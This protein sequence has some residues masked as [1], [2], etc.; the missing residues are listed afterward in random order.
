MKLISQIH[1]L[2][3]PTLALVALLAAGPAA[4]NGPIGDHVEDLQAHLEEYS[5]EVQWLIEQVDGIVDT[6]EADGAEAAEPAAVVDHWEAVKVHA[7]I[8]VNYVPVY[9]SIWQGLFGVREAIEKEKPV[10]EVCSQTGRAIS[11]KRPHRGQSG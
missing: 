2:R 11:A 3:W 9:A 7:A 6:Y 8:E 1:Q 5:N 10:A 4:A